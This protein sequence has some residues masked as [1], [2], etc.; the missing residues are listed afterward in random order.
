MKARQILIP[1]AIAMA[2]CLFFFAGPLIALF[3]VEGTALEFGIAHLRFIAPFF[4]L[5]C[6]YM[7]NAGALTGT[8]DVKAASGI[9]LAVLAVRVALTYLFRFGLH[10]GFASLYVPNPIG[11]VVG[12]GLSFLRFRGGKWENMSV[13]KR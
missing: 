6:L 1:V 11:W 10:L 4:V 12:L 2:I 9:T 8:G 13:V 5:F 3:G 7:S